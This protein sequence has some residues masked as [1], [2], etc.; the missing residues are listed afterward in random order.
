MANVLTNVPPKT[1][2]WLWAVLGQEYRDPHRAYSD[3]AHTL[4]LYPG[5]APRTD[6]Y[7]FENG[8]HAL[9]VRL[10]GTVPANFRGTVYRFPI[11]LWI[12]HAY[13][14]EAPI[15]YVTP[16]EEMVVRQ[17]QHVAGDG[18]IYHHYLAHW[19][20]AWDRSHV[21]DLLTVLSAIFA[22]EPPQ[23]QHPA[24][25][26]R[27]PYNNNPPNPSSTNPQL[28]LPPKQPLTQEEQRA[29]P[30]QLRP[31]RYEAPLPL[32]QQLSTHPEPAHGNGTIPY[33]TSPSQYMPQ[34]VSSLRQQGPRIQA[35]QL[36]LRPQP[37]ALPLQGQVQ[38][39][40]P[41]HHYVQQ[42]RVEPAQQA[43]PPPNAPQRAPQ[44]SLLDSPFDIPLPVA[45]QNLPAPPIP[46]NPEKEALLSHLSSVLTN[47]LHSQIQQNTAAM[48][49]LQSQNAALQSTIPRL[50]AELASLSALQDSLKSN[51]GLLQESLSK[52][53]QTISSARQRAAAGDIP[54]VDEMLVPPHLVGKQLYDTVTEERGIEAAIFAL[55]DAF[56]RGRVSSDAWSRKTR[57]LAREGFKKRYLTRKIATGMGLEA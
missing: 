19:P 45:H 14:Y 33:A 37:Q 8:S 18:R 35:Q 24:A 5:L 3:L 22:N 15:V 23:S 44:A 17:G 20:D 28:P 51:I 6:V 41:S 34:R 26:P 1:L 54:K 21:A 10:V 4:S 12:P 31:G 50:Q 30:G 16:T 53:D 25:P 11:A 9:L 46:R 56:V 2:S 7:T 49:P 32:P 39:A 57:E 40:Q 43:P 38:P 42:P 47:S 52:A 29:S 36:P 13:P 55:Q 27:P 48:Q